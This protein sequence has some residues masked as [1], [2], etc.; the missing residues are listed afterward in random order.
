MSICA[1]RTDTPGFFIPCIVACAGPCRCG[2]DVR[3]EMAPES[4]TIA[5]SG[6]NSGAADPN[7][8]DVICG[9]QIADLRGAR[10]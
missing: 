3:A 9:P 5:R 7:T 1:Y 6:E 4:P 2:E 10:P 8:S